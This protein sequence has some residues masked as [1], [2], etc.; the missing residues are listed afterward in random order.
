[1]L[2]SQTFST[3]DPNA[4][5]MIAL[6]EG[7]GGLSESDLRNAAAQLTEALSV[8]GER[9]SDVAEPT[10]GDD[11]ATKDYVDGLSGGGGIATVKG[12]SNSRDYIKFEGNPILQNTVTVTGTDTISLGGGVTAASK[13]I[14]VG[15][16]I[17]LKNSVDGANTGAYGKV[18][19]VSGG[20][21]T[22]DTSDFG[23]L[24]NEVGK[25]YDVLP[26]INLKAPS[27]LYA[28][29]EVLDTDNND[30]NKQGI[31]KVTSSGAWEVVKPDAGTIVQVS[32]GETAVPKFWYVF[33]YDQDMHPTW[34]ALVPYEASFGRTRGYAGSLTGT[35]VLQDK[36]DLFQNHPALIANNTV[37]MIEAA[38]TIRGGT[39]RASVK[40]FATLRK[41]SGTLTM[42]DVDCY[43]HSGTDGDFDKATI[44]GTNYG[45]TL[46]VTGGKAWLAVRVPNAENGAFVADV[47]VTKG[48]G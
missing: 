43:A 40:M 24:T 3:S 41:D 38:V 26:L 29:D 10:Q 4:W 14:S 44:G 19:A 25:T 45:F 22:I 21:I 39:W 12:K 32:Y 37:Y 28:D 9:I 31:A 20:D 35:G 15:C 30:L 18:T 47:T 13:N 46:Q 6:A 7:G 42:E 23:P 2:K 48:Q 27:V 17:G 34:D 1:M 33:V 36:V 16:A 8:N 5:E 11:A